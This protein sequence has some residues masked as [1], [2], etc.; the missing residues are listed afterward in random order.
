MM[1]MLLLTRVRY[2]KM[3]HLNRLMLGHA[4]QPKVWNGHLVRKNVNKI[5]FAQ[6]VIRSVNRS[7][8]SFVSGVSVTITEVVKQGS[9]L[10]A[11]TALRFVLSVRINL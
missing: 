8:V 6:S 4:E 9:L 11:F 5:H 1:D 10:D 3:I 7:Y 2:S